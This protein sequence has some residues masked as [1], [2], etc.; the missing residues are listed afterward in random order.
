MSLNKMIT[1]METP[2]PPP[3]LMDYLSLLRIRYLKF[4]NK[5]ISM[6]LLIPLRIG[7]NSHEYD[8]AFLLFFIFI[9][10]LKYFNTIL[11]VADTI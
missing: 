11:H 9:G 7:Y 6:I 3:A 2:P 4:D 10:M 8:I 1:L 5:K